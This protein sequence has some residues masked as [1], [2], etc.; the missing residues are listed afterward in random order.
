[1]IGHKTKAI[2]APTVRKR[3]R[4]SESCSAKEASVYYRPC[5]YCDQKMTCERRAKISQAAKELGL[6]SVRVKCEV[7]Y[8]LFPPGTTV[9]VS[10]PWWR[11]SITGVVSGR[12]RTRKDKLAVWLDESPEDTPNQRIACCFPDI[13]RAIEAPLIRVCPE[14]G[15]PDGYENRPDWWCDACVLRKEAR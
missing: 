9:E 8:A 3:R 6:T 13:L 11:D 2:L 1:M 14:C 4:E 5:V 10:S 15:K 7:P 12:G